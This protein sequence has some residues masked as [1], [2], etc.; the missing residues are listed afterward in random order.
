MTDN[1]TLGLI[2]YRC[3]DAN[4]NSTIRFDA[5]TFLQEPIT[6]LSNKSSIS[7]AYNSSG[8]IFLYKSVFFKNVLK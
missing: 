3:E 7:G 1:K 6:V 5:T 4:K 8:L 2:I